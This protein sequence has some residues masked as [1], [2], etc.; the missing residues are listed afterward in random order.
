M[1]TDLEGRSTIGSLPIRAGGC[2]THAYLC[3]KKSGQLVFSGSPDY[4]DRRP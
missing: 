2:R 1:R 4:R 3:V